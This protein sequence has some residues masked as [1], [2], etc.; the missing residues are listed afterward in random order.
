[1]KENILTNRQICVQHNV[2]T[3][4]IYLKHYNFFFNLFIK[5]S[6]KTNT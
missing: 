1:M 3:K 4:Q 2:Y 6:K 5:N